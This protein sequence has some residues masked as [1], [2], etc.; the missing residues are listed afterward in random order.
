MIDLHI[1]LDGD[2]VRWKVGPPVSST[3]GEVLW[4][5]SEKGK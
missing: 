1:W 5:V 2:C 3:D 4:K